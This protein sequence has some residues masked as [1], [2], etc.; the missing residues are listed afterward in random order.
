[1]LSRQALSSGLSMISIGI[2]LCVLAPP[3]ELDPGTDL[4]RQRVSRGPKRVRDQPFREA[5]RNEDPDFPLQE[6]VAAVSEL[7]LLRA[8]RP[9][10]ATDR[11]PGYAYTDL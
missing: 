7:F 9:I 2:S 5:F 6:L 1:M 10:K 4:L 11:R 3:G 8:N